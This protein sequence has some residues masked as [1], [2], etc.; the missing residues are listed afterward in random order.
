MT[1]L[2]KLLK[3]NESELGIPTADVAISPKLVEL[4][5]ENENAEILNRQIFEQYWGRIEKGD[6]GREIW[7]FGASPGKSLVGY[8]EF[9]TTGGAL[10]RYKVAV[11]MWIPDVTQ[12]RGTTSFVFSRLAGN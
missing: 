11:P 8:L 12:F 3:F 6:D 4:I 10:E 9:A 5:L 2:L 7:H 1:K